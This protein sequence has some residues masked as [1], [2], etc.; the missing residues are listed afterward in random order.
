MPSFYLITENTLHVEAGDRGSG[1]NVSGAGDA[2]AVRVPGGSSSVA[3][4]LPLGCPQPTAPALG[5][6]GAVPLPVGQYF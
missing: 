4:T 6:A 1:A 5:S 2:A 3:V